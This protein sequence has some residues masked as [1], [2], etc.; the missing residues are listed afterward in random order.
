[1]LFPSLSLVIALTLS[2][3]VPPQPS[4]SREGSQFDHVLIISI[5][6][7]RPEALG[8]PLVG[9]LPTLTRLLRGPHTLD[10]RTDADF[11]ITLPNH[12]AMLTGRPVDGP[13]GHGWKLNTDPPGAT[14]GGTLHA[15]RGFYVAS[16]FDVAHDAGVSTMVAASKTK[17]WLLEQSYA[18]KAAQPDRSEPDYGQPKI[19]VFVFAEAMRDVGHSVAD[20]LRR[21][22]GP[23]LDFVH[24]AAP[25]I[26]GHSYDWIISSESKYFAAI[27]TVDAAL[28]PILEAIDTTPA[29]CGRTAIIL[30]ADHGGGVPR[31]TH[32]DA[33]CPLNFR[34]PFLVW[35]G[36][37]APASDLIA[38]NP[39]RPRPARESR[40]AR[41]DPAQPIRNADAGNLALSL[42]G[43][44]PIP[45][46]TY[47]NP[48]SLRLATPLQTQPEK[49]TP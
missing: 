9:Q 1:M 48:R 16:V 6:G 43:L 38:L 28:A 18:S 7:L 31:K 47:G 40:V 32:T 14:Q 13:E 24:F 29:L 12:V 19:D 3:A 42:L 44:P 15:N 30:T 26:A 5:D 49:L 33:T 36:A 37:D 25:D 41:T 39:D 4:E 17:F 20:R 10:A 34:I 2:S 35:L 11:T 46:S 21:A 23:T 45:G 27:R 8:P 22:S